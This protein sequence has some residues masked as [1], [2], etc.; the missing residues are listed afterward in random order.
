MH[1]KMSIARLSGETY[2]AL[3]KCLDAH[4]MNMANTIQFALFINLHDQVSASD[5]HAT[6]SLDSYWEEQV[7][8]KA[9]SFIIIIIIIITYL[10]L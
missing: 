10:V 2:G 7:V 1:R 3:E 9:A 6:E 4:P 8:L 5:P